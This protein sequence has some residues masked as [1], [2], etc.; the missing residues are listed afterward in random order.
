MSVQT[1]FLPDLAHINQSQAISLS[2][3]LIAA[4]LWVTEWTPLYIT[5]FIILFL[6]VTWLLPTLH[7]VVS[8][9]DRQAYYSP[10]FSDI[11]LLF[12]GGF[13]LASAL[14]K[15]ALDARIANWLLKR[16]GSKPANVMLGMMIICAILSMWMSNTA[17]TAMMFAILLPILDKIPA[18]NPFSKALALCIPFAC[19]LGGLGTPIGTPPNAIAM[20]YLA[21]AGLNISFGQWM[22]ATFPFL[23]LF[24]GLLWFVLLKIYPPGDLVLE[25]PHMENM[26]LTAKHY[27]IIFTFLLTIL[28]WL[29]TKVH[30]YSIGTASLLP[31]LLIFGSGLLKS[32]D[33]KQLPWDVLFMV[34]GGIC[35]GV[36][37]KESGLTK[38]I[39]NLVPVGAQVITI[40]ITFAVLA[41]LMTTFMSN[42]A[43]ANLLIPLAVSIEG[44]VSL[45]ILTIALCCSTAMA[46]PVS[47]PPNAI[48]FGSGLLETRDMIKPGVIIT[49]I[50]LVGLLSFGSLY[51]PIVL[52][53]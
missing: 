15:Y 31:V 28:G 35:L 20:N 18:G 17:T 3:L 16:T 49:L 46:L 27:F 25:L 43:T 41:S 14:H 8:T 12:L 45:I 29:T 9:S 26:P 42:T 51:W 50:A 21:E 48:A 23:I 37:L 32:S 30:G 24:L 53:V 39:V 33:F 10:F 2:I 47:T 44:P 40:I 5:S 13:I 36:G 4:T 11:I 1:N 38:E 34:G 22:M 52:G 7:K 19:N 6:Q